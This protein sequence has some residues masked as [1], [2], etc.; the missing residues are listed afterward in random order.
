M[1]LSDQWFT[2]SYKDFGTGFSMQI[3]SCLQVEKTPICTVAIYDTTHFGKMM[4]IDDVIMLTSRDNFFY[5]EMLTHPALFSHPD[6]K[7]V[8]IIGGGD[9]G[10]LKEVL[11]HPVK[12]VTQ[13]EIEEKVTRLAEEYFPELCTS[14]QDPRATLIF[15]D[16]IKWMQEAPSDSVDIIIVDSTDPVGPAEGLF[17]RAFYQEC[18]RVLRKDGLLIQQS[19]SP[20]LHQTLLCDIRKAMRS[21]G[22]QTLLTLPFP[23]VVYPS[24]WHSATLASKQNQDFTIRKDQAILKQC[25]LQYYHFPLHEAALT[26]IPLLARLFDKEGA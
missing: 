22:F 6:P 21:A 12:S 5:H 18:F 7:D 8:V 10:T 26:P 14:N 4:T 25:E 15:A 20:I 2:E 19:E 1:T 17:N 16:G 23:Q 9:C 13:I 3:R 24:G 11:K